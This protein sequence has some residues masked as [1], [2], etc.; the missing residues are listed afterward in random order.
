MG[1]TRVTVWCTTDQD[2]RMSAPAR[3]VPMAPNTTKGSGT[4]GSKP[5]GLN[6]QGKPGKKPLKPVKAPRPWGLIAL[7]VAVVV[8]AAG[9]IT[10]AALQAQGAGKPFGER[11]A[12][13]VEGVVNFRKSDPGMLKQE[14]RGGKQTYKTSPPVGG[15]HNAAW[16]N[17]MGDVYPAQIPNEHAVHSMEHGA[18]WLTYRPDLPKAQVDALAAKVQGND[19]I[20]MSPYP[21]LDKPVSLQAWGFQLKLDSATDSRVEKFIQGFSQAASVENGATCGQGLT[22]TGTEPAPMAAGG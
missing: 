16:Q 19:F 20:L 14:H 6:R 3:K 18:V 8:A 11:P 15:T 17:C 21:G 10:Y 12:Q 13:Q 1:L 4:P 7:G 5:G 9:I 22:T 2:A